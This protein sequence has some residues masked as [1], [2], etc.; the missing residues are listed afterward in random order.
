MRPTRIVVG[1]VRGAEALDMLQAMNTGHDGS[2]STVH[3]NSPRD[4]LDRLTTLAMMGEE[5]LAAEVVT[6]MVARAIEVVVQLRFEPRVGRRRVVSVFEV[7]GLE[8]DT[9]AGNDLWT[10]DSGRDRLVWSGIPPRCLAKMRA[11]GVAYEPPAPEVG[12]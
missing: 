11:R 2:L 6:R 4:A 12:R 8:G 1:E 3:G 5:R 10:Y 9:L 7:T